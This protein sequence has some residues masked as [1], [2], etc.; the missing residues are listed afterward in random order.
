M[1]D[2]TGK[3]VLVRSAGA[4]VHYGDF[5]AKEGEEVHLKNSRRIWSWQGALSLSEIVSQG[6]DLK[7]SKISVPVDEIVVNGVKETLSLMP[8][9]NLP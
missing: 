8:K 9:C 4:G 6:V 3:R 5:V 1:I 7:A 2:F